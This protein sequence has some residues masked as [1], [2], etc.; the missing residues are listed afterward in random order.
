MEKKMGFKLKEFQENWR[1]EY[2]AKKALRLA[3]E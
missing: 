3:K 1:K 2:A